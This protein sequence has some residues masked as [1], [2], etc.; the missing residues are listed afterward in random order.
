MLWRREQLFM[1]WR[2]SGL[3]VRTV[4]ARREEE[5]FHERQFNYANLLARWQKK[6]FT[7][8]LS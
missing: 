3:K 8:D 7:R 2:Q 5:I 6:A 4:S 1:L